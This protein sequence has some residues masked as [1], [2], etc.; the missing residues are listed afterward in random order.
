MRS[1]GS[2]ISTRSGPTTGSN[3]GR[4]TRDRRRL[5]CTPARTITQP[6]SATF[7]LL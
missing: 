6:P 3:W 4:S 5:R 1:S 2:S 7:M